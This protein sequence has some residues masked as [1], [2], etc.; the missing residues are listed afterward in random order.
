M[1]TELIFKIHHYLR[2]LFYHL[3][4]LRFVHL[5]LQMFQA[6]GLTIHRVQQCHQ[7]LLLLPFQTHL[8]TTGQLLQN[9]LQV[10]SKWTLLLHHLLFIGKDIVQTFVL[11]NYSPL[12]PLYFAPL[13]P[14]ESAPSAPSSAATSIRS[15]LNEESIELGTADAFVTD[16]KDEDAPEIESDEPHLNGFYSR[17][18]SL[19][20]IVVLME[21]QLH[22]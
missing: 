13:N 3:L 6:C 20:A 21:L 14:S 9:L 12:S 7:C 16:V 17:T 19:R 5:L 15:L 11:T 8:Q 2:W 4:L 1:R 22:V 10:L 18:C